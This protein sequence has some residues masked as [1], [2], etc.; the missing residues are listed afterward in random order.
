MLL[1]MQDMSQAMAVQVLVEGP[2]P[3]NPNEA[4]GRTT[5]NKLTFFPAPQGA[6]Q[7]KGQLVDV[8][9]TTVHA[10][11]LFGDMVQ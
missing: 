6:A 10:F 5:H 2:N 7:L 9:I 8:H 1:R 3:K 4:M 11:S